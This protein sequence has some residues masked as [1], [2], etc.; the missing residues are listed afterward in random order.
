MNLTDFIEL[1]GTRKEIKRSEKKHTNFAGNQMSYDLGF[2]AQH[3]H[4]L[5]S[6][7]EFIKHIDAVFR[8]CYDQ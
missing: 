3:F 2:S 6:V 4:D 7:S 8:D 5:S 1:I